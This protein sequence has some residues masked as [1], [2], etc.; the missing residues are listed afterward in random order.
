MENITIQ[1]QG[2]YYYWFFLFIIN[3]II[4]AFYIHFTKSNYYCQIFI[5]NIIDIESI[6]NF[7]SDTILFLL[8][9]LLVDSVNKNLL[10]CLF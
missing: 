5:H 4:I 7:N 6:Y 1:S 3:C 10:C 9:I 8:I 2:F